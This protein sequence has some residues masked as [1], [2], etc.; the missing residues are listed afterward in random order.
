MKRVRQGV[1]FLL[2]AAG[3]AAILLFKSK[4]L[5]NEESI[6]LRERLP[7]SDILMRINVLEL[8]KK[9]SPI[10]YKYKLPVREFASPDFLLSQGKQFGV[11]IQ[12]E[13]FMFANRNM[14]EWG[15]LVALNDSSKVMNFV[16]K[17][18][19]STQIVDSSSGDIRILLF[20]EQQIVLCYQNN[21]A[22]IYSGDLLTKRLSKIKDGRNKVIESAWARFFQRSVKKK[23]PVIAYSEGL[24]L[25]PW[26]I[27]Y[28]LMSSENDSTNVRLTGHVETLKPHGFRF[29]TNAF[30]LPLLSSDSKAVEL[31]L[32]S[33]FKQQEL[34]KKL[35]SELHRLGMK[36]GFPTSLFMSSWN[37][38]L[39][40]RE[41]GIVN[42][43]QRVVVTEFD[44]NF[45]PRETIQYQK[46]SVPGYAIMLGINPTAKTF[47]NA[48]YTKGILSNEGHK[49][50]F[51]YAPLL[52]MKTEKERYRF[53]SSSHFPKLVPT[54]D[55]FVRWTI[56]NETCFFSLKDYGSDY[57][58]ITMD[59]PS[60]M[61][62]KEWKKNK[63][64]KI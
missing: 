49:L 64:K 29:I 50:R 38:N 47:L 34:T 31:H 51:L 23:D 4:L 17:F 26:G 54:Y 15:I 44:E 59:L 3:L 22:L 52:T 20:K 56:N 33:S 19:K 6:S 43:T 58:T 9:M 48:L 37:G 41:G 10:L 7:V 24:Y 11:N 1:W 45:N 60:K 13:A 14:T 18:R 5:H 40:F 25:Q 42:S 21:Y 30:G 16:D 55:N 62:V 57:F 2:I 35:T 63:R 36:I 46:I 39:S 8:S 61:L 27:A 28:I 32:D 53:S 12:S